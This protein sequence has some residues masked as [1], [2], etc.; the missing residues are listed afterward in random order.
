MRLA[1][2]AGDIGMLRQLTCEAYSAHGT[3]MCVVQD[4]LLISF[5]QIVTSMMSMLNVASWALLMGAMGQCALYSELFQRLPPWIIF[6][7][8]L[9]PWLTV[10]TISFCRQ[11]PL[12][13]RRFRHCLIFAMCW[14]AIMTLLAETLHLVIHPSPR[15]HFS[16]TVARVLTYVGALTFIV[17]VRA[18]IQLRRHEGTTSP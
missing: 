4:L 5:Q 13:P 18:C 12:G 6:V 16:I 15:G 11:A 17:F 9:P 7:A 14:Y 2:V 8:L 10:Y 1:G 3:R